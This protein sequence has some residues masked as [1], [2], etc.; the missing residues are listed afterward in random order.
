M[1]TFDSLNSG[2]SAHGQW[3]QRLAQAIKTGESD[4]TPVTVKQDNQ[5]EFGKWL[6]DCSPDEQA[7]PHYATIKKM[8]AEFHTCAGAILEKALAGNVADAEAEIGM[9]SQYRTIS[10]GLTTEMMKWKD[11]VEG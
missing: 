2:I 3:K 6:Y 4:F 11:E 5:C 8:H 9:G 7:S 1:S 10:A